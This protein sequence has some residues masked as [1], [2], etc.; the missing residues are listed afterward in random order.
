MGKMQFVKEALADFKKEGELP[1]E[2]I[3]IF[4]PIVP[5]EFIYVWKKYGLGSFLDGYLR[6]IDP[7]AFAQLAEEI[8]AWGE[9]CV[10]LMVT[11]LGD[12]LVWDAEAH[13][14]EMIFCRYGI[15]KMPKGDFFRL[16]CDKSYVEKELEP[17]N[18]KEAVELHGVPDFDEC[19]GYVPLLALG[20]GETPDHLERCKVREHIYLISQMAGRIEE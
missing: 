5:E 9:Q 8:V 2:F 17:I 4:K 18:Y 19:F 15:Y 3:K 12:M 16:L 11:A 14:L 10:P 13:S 7:R 1:S 20:G 6:V